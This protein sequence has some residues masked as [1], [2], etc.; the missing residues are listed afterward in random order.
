DLG[1]WRWTVDTPEDLEHLR[2]MVAALGAGVDLTRVS[3]TEFARF[4]EPH[5]DTSGVTLRPAFAADSDLLLQLRND[6]D[7][8]RFSRTRAGVDRAAHARWFRSALADPGRELDVI[9]LDGR[10]VGSLRTDVRSAVGTVSIA[11]DR[12][13]RGHGIAARALGLIQQRAAGGV[14]L[15]RLRA[16]VDP[17]NLMS[18]A[19][20]ERAGFVKVGAADGFDDMEWSPT[21]T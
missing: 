9:C 8:I 7:S 14:R 11:V 13:S 4:A 1:R 17:A 12:R 3:W 16:I 2:G 20:F 18:V 5:V 19:L 15:D 10:P 6:A 21:V